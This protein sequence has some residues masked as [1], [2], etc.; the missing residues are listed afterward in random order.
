MN[1][2]GWFN[3]VLF[4]QHS[5]AFYVDVSGILHMCNPQKNK[6]CILKKK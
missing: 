2:L 4:V 3:L 6:W 5:S 1:S